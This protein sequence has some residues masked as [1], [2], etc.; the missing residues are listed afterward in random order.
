MLQ[1]NGFQLQVSSEIGGLRR[2]LIHSPDRGLGQ[3]IPSKAQDW[4]FED[5]VHLETVRK[6][7]YDLYV[8]VLLYFLDPDLVKGKIKNIDAK[9]STRQFYKP[10]QPGFY[11]SNKVI[12]LEA[13]LADILE[14][15]AVRQQLVAAVC[16][17]EHCTNQQQQML[18]ALPSADLATLFIS[19]TMPNKKIFFAPVPNLI[20]TRDLGTTINNHVLLN[21]PAKKAR[22]REALLTKYIFFNHP[23]F[24]VYRQ[25][26]IEVPQ[27]D[28]H[29]LIPEGEIDQQN[30]LEGGDVMMVSKNHLLIGCGER[31]TPQAASEVIQILFEK[32]VVQ[33]VTVIK[34]PHKRDFMHLDTVFTQ[35]KKNLWVLLSSLF[36]P[37]QK[38][39]DFL[40]INHLIETKKPDRPEIIQ[41][42][43]GKINTP[44]RFNKLEDLLCDISENELGSTEKTQFIYSG[45][46]VFPYDSRE[47]WTD[48]C[49]L[50]A[51][52]EGVVLAYDRNDKTLAAF[53]NK[54]FTVIKAA[55]LLQQFENNEL[56]PENLLNTVITFPSAE[57]SRARG[58]FHCM[59]MPLFRDEL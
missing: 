39:Q 38:D 25:N 49:N 4:L 33:K 21:K 35:V 23:F 32:N 45:N 31:T 19:G 10:N 9:N 59:S 16:A 29:F 36:N 34:I 44:R 17:V 20:F 56:Q 46:N 5:I 1:K 57:L 13:L 12:E 37:E 50:L 14:G 22:S 51:L 6:K 48:G 18:L 8:K 2:I 15:Q 3:V 28:Q 26:I 7:E 47:Q 41:F 42:E 40:P 30:T 54:G 43:K 11:A 53:K 24:E 52:K 27:T 58:G 55:D